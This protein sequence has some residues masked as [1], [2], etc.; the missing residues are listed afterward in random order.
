MPYIVSVAQSEVHD[1]HQKSSR[2]L[3]QQQVLGLE[4]AMSDLVV[5]QLLNAVKQLMK[6]HTRLSLWDMSIGY[7]I[8]EH[9]A[10]IYKVAGQ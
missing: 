6:Q 1:L 5:V 7:N 2:T 4:V 10:P 8:V 3:L 9:L